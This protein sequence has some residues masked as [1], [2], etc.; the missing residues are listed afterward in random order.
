MYGN[1]THRLEQRLR[2]VTEDERETD[3]ERCKRDKRSKCVA[4]VE[5]EQTDEEEDQGDYGKHDRVELRHSGAYV[6]DCNYEYPL[7]LPVV[8][9]HTFKLAVNALRSR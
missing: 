4:S 6:L 1:D 9:T 3:D 7:Q 5:D 2:R 8:A